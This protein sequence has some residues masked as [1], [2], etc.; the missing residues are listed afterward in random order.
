MSKLIAARG[1]QCPQVAEFTFNFD[2]TMVSSAGAEK[3]FGKTNIAETAFDLAPLP[4][5]AIVIGGD[6]ITETA[7]DTA[8]YS[9]KVGDATTADRYLGA[10]DKKGTGRTALVPTGFRST[11]EKLRLTVT[12]ADVCTAGKMSLRVMFVI[13][14]R[15]NEVYL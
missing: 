12:N 15:I 10:T 1:S 7:F 11:G 8:S 3:D 4:A 5:G 14:D 13:A 2:D 6:V 9:I